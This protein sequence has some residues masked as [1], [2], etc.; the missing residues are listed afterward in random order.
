MVKGGLFE[1]VTVKRVGTPKD[2][3]IGDGLTSFHVQP[4][5]DRVISSL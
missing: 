3:H 2:V 1:G 4:I 5:P